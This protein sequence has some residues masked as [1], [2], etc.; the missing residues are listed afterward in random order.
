MTQNYANPHMHLLIC[1]DLRHLRLSA[2]GSFK[3]KYKTI[4]NPDFVLNFGFYKFRIMGLD[5]NTF[6]LAKHDL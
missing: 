6:Y 3:K 1:E 5:N 2:T 4:P